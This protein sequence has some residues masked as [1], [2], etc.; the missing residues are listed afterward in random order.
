MRYI[1]FGGEEYYPSD[2][3]NDILGFGD[4]VDD[5]AQS[6][7][8]TGACIDWWHIYDLQAKKIVIKRGC[9]GDEG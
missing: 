5:L 3:A 2:G 1:L 9:F 4:S 6:E 7:S 8:L